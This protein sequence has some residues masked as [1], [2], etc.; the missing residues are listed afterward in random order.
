MNFLK[1]EFEAII[2]RSKTLPQHETQKIQTHVQ[3]EFFLLQTNG[4]ID[5]SFVS[6]LNSLNTDHQS[7]TNILEH[8][9]S[10]ID[11]STV[12]KIFPLIAPCYT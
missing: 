12:K 11:K 1:N 6:A 10:K 2:V 5:K 9:Y 3:K 8:D 4:K 7:E